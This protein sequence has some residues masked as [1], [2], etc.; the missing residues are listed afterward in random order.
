MNRV[1]IL[2][3]YKGDTEAN[4]LYGWH[5]VLDSVQRGEAPWASHLFYTVVLND[6]DPVQR[7]KGFE[8]EAAWLRA[9]DLVAVYTD[10]GLSS[11]MVKT[12]DMMRKDYPWIKTEMRSIK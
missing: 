10:R 4:L 11:G 5:C 1:I 8:C 7:A 3:P 2:S 12:L 6:S 9:A